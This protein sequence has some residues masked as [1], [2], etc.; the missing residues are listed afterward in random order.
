MPELVSLL[1]KAKFKLRAMVLPHSE[2]PKHPF[3]WMQLIIKLI[4]IFMGDDNYG[5]D[6]M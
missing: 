1:K 5:T 6:S 4:I 3:A 2:Q